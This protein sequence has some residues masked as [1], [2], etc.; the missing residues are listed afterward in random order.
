MMKYRS[1]RHLRTEPQYIGEGE[2]T[3]FLLIIWRY[4]E[5]NPVLEI[6]LKLLSQGIEG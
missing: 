6:L 4:F 2:D 5:N 1:K 3:K